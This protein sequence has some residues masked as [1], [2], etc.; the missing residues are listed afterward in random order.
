MAKEIGTCEWVTKATP[1]MRQNWMAAIR[2]AMTLLLCVAQGSTAN[3]DPASCLEK[4]TSYVAEVDQ[5]LATEK[6]G[7]LRLMIS[8]SDILNLGIA[9]RMPCWRWF[10]GRAFSSG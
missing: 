8:T 3:A 2:A 9:I 10:G 7:S 5:L 1:A 6:I 4:V